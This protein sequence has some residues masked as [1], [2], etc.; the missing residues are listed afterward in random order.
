MLTLHDVENAMG[1]TP[2]DLG[3]QVLYDLCRQH[4][5]H[6]DEQAVI[7][8]I[9]IIGRV[10]AAAIERRRNK[11]LNGDKMPTGDR[12]YREV[13]LPNV[14]TSDLDDW[15]F[16]AR[17]AQPSTPQGIATLV[18]VHC[19]TMNLFKDISGL[20]KRSLASKYLHFH[21]PQL[22]YILDA[23]AAQALRN[24]DNDVPR[25]TRIVGL[26]DR[27]YR[28]FVNRC[29]DLRGFCHAQFGL[30][31]GPRKIDNLLLLL[32]ADARSDPRGHKEPEGR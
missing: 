28:G 19:R 31:M 17:A 18:D 20:E 10:Y 7:A 13:V 6:T 22:F 27:E 14:L 29:E 32:Q 4:P 24:L 12:F 21:V 2:W 9:W 16:E 1:P 8:K 5:G 11:T 15:L 25:E 30:N 26:G 23:R 3:N